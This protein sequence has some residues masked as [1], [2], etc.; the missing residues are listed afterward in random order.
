MPKMGSDGNSITSAEVCTCKHLKHWAEG[1]YPGLLCPGIVR[2]LMGVR[3]MMSES[4]SGVERMEVEDAALVRCRD[5]VVL[6]R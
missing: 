5:W 2:C 3:R 1:G 6:W 4:G